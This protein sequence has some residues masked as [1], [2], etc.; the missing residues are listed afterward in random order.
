M[1]VLLLAAACGDGRADGEEDRAEP[2]GDAGAES[3]RVP[4]AGSPVADAEFPVTFTDRSGR[5]VRFSAP[6]ERIVSLVPS[7]TGILLA[8]GAGDRLVG[9]TDYD[10]VSAVADRPSVGGGLQPAMETLLVLDPDL[11]IRFAGQSDPATVRRLD[12]SGIRHVAVRPDGIDDVLWSVRQLGRIVGRS[13]RALALA[14]EIEAGLD[15]VRDRVRGR[16]PPKVA[17]V[18]GGSPPWVAGPATFIHEL[19]GV[20]GGENV[21]ADVDELYPVVSLEEFVDREIDLLLT[22]PGVTPDPA[23]R[24]IPRRTVPGELQRPGADLHEAA[25]AL[26]RI[27]HPEAFP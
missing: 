24:A 14:A 19:I 25:R 4:G 10:T 9:R 16:P 6:P 12:A 18:V 7:V 22:P 1:V 20:A 2:A 11:V 3:I 8:L 23:L 15:S 27:L 17:F 13:G 26:A 21:F 5:E